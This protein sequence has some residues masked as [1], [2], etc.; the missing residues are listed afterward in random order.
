MTYRKLLTLFSI[1]LVLSLILVACAGAEEEPTEVPAPAEEEEAAPAEEEEAAPAEEEE[2]APPE[3]EMA[4][5]DWAMIPGGFLERALTGEFAGTTVIYDGPFAD[6]DIVLLEA[7]IA[8][9]EEATGID[10]NY[11]GDKEF[12]G[13]IAIAVDGGNAPDMADFPQP[14]LLAGFARQGHIVDP[15][16]FIPE[17]WLQQQYNQSW[18]DM[19]TMEGPDGQDQMAGTWYRMN[20][21]SQVFYPKAQFEAAG[22]EVPETWDELV[23]LTQTIADDGDPAWCIGIGSGAATGWP[24]TDWTEDVMLRT[25]GTEAYD[26]WVAGTLPFDSPEVREAIDTWSEI[27][28]NPDYVFGG[29]DFIVSTEFSDAVE[30]MFQDPP[31]CWLHRQGN[32]ITAFF[33]EGVEFGTDWDMFYLPP[34][35][36]EHGRPFLVAGDINAMFND[37]PEVRAF[38][39]FTTIPESAIGWLQN[40]GALATHQTVTPDMY[41]QEVERKLAEFVNAA[42]DF[43]FDGSDL[44]PG[45]VGAGS[46]WTGMV[47]YVSGAADIDTILPE[48]DATWPAGVAGEVQEEAAAEAAPEEAEEPA[49]DSYLGRALAGEFDGTEVLIQTVQVDED[50]A[51]FEATLESFEE[52]T[53]ITINHAGTK[54]HETQIVVQ[55]EGGNA[56]DIAMFSQPALL[57]T[58]VSAGN[59]ADVREFIAEEDLQERY[60]QGWLDSAI[61]EGPDGEDLMAGVWWKAANKDLVWYNKAQFEAAGYEVPTTWDEML[62][63]SD[64]IVADGDAPWCIGIESGVATGWVATDWIEALMLR[65]APPEDYDAWVAGELPFSSPQVTNATQLMADI[66]LNPDYVL[67]GTDQLLTE[68]ISDSPGHMFEDPPTCWLHRQAA[69]ITGS[70]GEGLEAGVDYDFF[71]LPPVDPQYGEPVL[72][73]G[74][75]MT[76]FN[77]RPEVR[78]VLEYL[79]TADSIELYVRNGRGM[80]PHANSSLDWYTNDID[81]QAAEILLNAETVRFDASDIMPAEV[82]AGTFWSGMVDFVSGALTM[83]EALQEIDDSWPSG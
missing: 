25:A 70:F 9:F 49:A 65:T 5:V 83:E 16:T 2:A 1:L 32:F 44:M 55:V 75:L 37:R 71:Y 54:E 62:E 69:W 53:G 28:F 40:G 23:A 59:V 80:S 31:Q 60:S 50:G 3:E 61:F 11:I 63:L 46:F 22:Y 24:A 38:M 17:E 64:T 66:W 57:Q 45:E 33:P 35:K 51:N 78:A 12:E 72:M 42:T 43:R 67:G 41:G 34:I 20:T 19:A 36:E 15:T 7:S 27:W 14:G 6:Q 52:A 74:D 81:R 79:S 48:I 29:T 47:D 30:P 10:I 82:G 73:A 68:N 56:P 4:E 76:M 18:L 21:K 39:E 13:R 58:F 8:P 77:D 26:A